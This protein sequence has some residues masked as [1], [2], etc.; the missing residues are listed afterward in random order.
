MY[1][2]FGGRLGGF[3]ILRVR[4]TF[5]DK[6]LGEM[7]VPYKGQNYHDYWLETLR[8]EH[9]PDRWKYLEFFCYGEGQ[10]IFVREGSLKD[11]ELSDWLNSRGPF[12]LPLQNGAKPE[13]AQRLLY[14]YKPPD[15]KATDGSERSIPCSRAMFLELN[16]FLMLPPC[17]CQP[18]GQKNPLTI[19]APK[20]PWSEYLSE[21]M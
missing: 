5:V 10:S 8:F 21:E 13:G 6:A 12:V 11:V 2:E 14:V 16:D 4:P 20:V 1:L 9:V 17:W 19:R 7:A 18:P 3:Q 15:T